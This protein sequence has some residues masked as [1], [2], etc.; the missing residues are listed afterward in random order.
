MSSTYSMGRG[1]Y[2]SVNFSM[3]C[4][5]LDNDTHTAITDGSKEQ[6]AAE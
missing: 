2:Q 6:A 4:T 1:G 3:D 5:I